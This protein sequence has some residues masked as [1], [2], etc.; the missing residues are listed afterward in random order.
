MKVL[1]QQGKGVSAGARLAIHELGL[2]VRGDRAVL[3]VFWK[4]L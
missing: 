1:D 3:L 2:P 4:R